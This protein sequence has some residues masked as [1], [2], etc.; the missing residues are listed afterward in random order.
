MLVVY[1]KVVEEVSPEVTDY[2][3]PDWEI[4]RSIAIPVPSRC[5]SAPQD[6]IV[7]RLDPPGGRMNGWFGQDTDAALRMYQTD[8]AGDISEFG[9]DISAMEPGTNQY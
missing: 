8:H 9:P 7:L 2:T 6:P 3:P 5:N 4:T 1:E